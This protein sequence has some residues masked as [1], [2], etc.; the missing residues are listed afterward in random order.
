MSGHV[1]VVHQHASEMARNAGATYETQFEPHS[2]DEETLYNVEK[3]LDERGNKFLV[4]WEGTDPQTGKK[5]PPDW[6]PKTDCTDDL[7]AE[8]KQA[9]ERRKRGRDSSVKSACRSRPSHPLEFSP[10]LYSL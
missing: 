4:Q 8:W 5:W 6:V 1:S 10:T 2:D 3:I 7:I 9:K